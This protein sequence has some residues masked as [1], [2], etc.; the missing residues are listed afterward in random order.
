MDPVGSLANEDVF[1][2]IYESGVN[3][4]TYSDYTYGTSGQ[5]ENVIKQLQLAEKYGISMFIR[6]G[7]LSNQ[8]Y[9]AEELAQ[10][11]ASYSMYRSFKGL[12]IWDEPSATD[13]TYGRYGNDNKT[14]DAY[15]KLSSSIQT[16][17]NLTAYTNLFP[18]DSSLG[19]ETA[20]KAY[21]EEYCKN[22]KPKI[23]SFDDY[24]F[25]DVGWVQAD[26]SNMRTYFR[27]LAIVREKAME[28]QIP[29]WAFVQAGSNWGTQAE[30][31]TN[32]ND[33]PTAE[34]FRWNVNM[35]L[36]FGAKG[37]QYFPLVQPDYFAETT[38]GTGND[39]KRNGLIG[40]DG[41]TINDWYYYAV[42][43]NNQ[44]KAV[45]AVLMKSESKG[46]MT[47]VD[48]L[49]EYNTQ[50]SGMPIFE[51]F[52]EITGIS[53]NETP[54]LLNTT[55]GAVAGCFDYRGKTAVYV[56]NYDINNANTITL[57]FDDTYTAQI[58]NYEGTRT[59]SGQSCSVSLPAGGAA[60]VIV[61]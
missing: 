23:L 41:V 16:Y 25:D 1:R 37:I 58:I 15:A 54:G 30:A 26:V 47:T 48:T 34:E 10:K 14:L 49:A 24:P 40:A 44:I 43:A 36:A 45:D 31:T 55:Y 19:T 3:L 2:L 57:S 52:Q 28:H 42:E 22:Y 18:L 6:D 50:D 13:G 61:E 11:L 33:T 35:N 51:Q 39:Y 56:V 60:L 29:F 7:R 8:D 20:Y 5:T 59:T 38:D 9:T 32:D 27:N 12:T 4:I 46:I 21:L 53:T 17:G